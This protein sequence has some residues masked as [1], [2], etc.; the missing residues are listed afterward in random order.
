[1][2][3]I[4]GLAIAPSDNPFGFQFVSKAYLDTYPFIDPTKGDAS[5]LNV[6]VTGSSKGIGRA[7]AISLARAGA[8]GIALLARSDLDQVAEEVLEAAKQAGRKEPKL[9]KLRVDI[10]DPAAVGEAIKDV[11]THFQ[12]LDVLVNNAGRLEAWVP[13][14][15][16]DVDDWWATWELNVKGTYVVTRAALPLVLKSTQ[17]TILT[18]SSGGALATFPGASAYQST[19]TMQLRLTDFLMAEYRD[20]GLIAYA[21][22]P[23]GAKT[24]L[25]LN[26]PTSRH[27]VLTQTVELAGDTIA[28]LTRERREWLA[29]RF[30][31]GP[32]SMEELLAKKDEI[33]EKDLLKLKLVI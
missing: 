29:G 3:K 28:W 9:L 1:M 17:K 2:A 18:V 16:T 24:E 20:Q 12:T 26:M 10:C 4:P 31:Y 13:L 6:L 5:G 7:A 21:I 14:A 32:G 30:V 22:H 27:D 25:A 19:K 8:S 15:E 33:V 11:E 23:C